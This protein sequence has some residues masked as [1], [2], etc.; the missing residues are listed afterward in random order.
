[1]AA[2]LV[3]AAM[4]V[5]QPLS[6]RLPTTT[7]TAQNKRSERMRRWFFIMRHL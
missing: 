2:E 4:A 6:T 1:V 7:T 5:P 3:V